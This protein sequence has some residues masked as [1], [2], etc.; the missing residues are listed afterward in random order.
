[1]QPEWPVMDFR[2]FT[3]PEQKQET[4]IESAEGAATVREEQK[5]IT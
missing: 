2:T 5:P 4:P 1:M 3:H